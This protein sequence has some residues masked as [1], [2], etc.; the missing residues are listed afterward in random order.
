[1]LTA[2]AG[3]GDV[4]KALDLG[5]N[6]YLIKP[7]DIEELIARVRNL[8][9]LGKTEDVLRDSISVL[10]H[11][12]TLGNIT[13]GVAHDLNN[14][15]SILEVHELIDMYI[16]KIK[17]EQTKNQI[18]ILG[19]YFD[20]IEDS[21]SSIKNSLEYGTEMCKSITDFVRGSG[22]LKKYQQIGPLIN[23][24]INILKRILK[25]KRITIIKDFEKDITFFCRAN[26]VKRMIMNL[27][28]NSVHALNNLNNSA[29]NKKIIY[30]KLRKKSDF[31]KLSISDNGAGISPDILHRIF[32]PLFTTKGESGNGIGLSTIKKIVD[33]YNGSIQVE[34]ELNKGTCFILLF[35][36]D[37]KNRR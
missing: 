2:K 14:I 22:F 24:P 32:D 8:V 19:M 4:V 31:L 18:K 13:A 30:M 6:D 10:E 7:F 16:K 3:T 34:S 23:N 15:L 26:D 12:A 25:S 36:I 17:S 37:Q 27:L 1:M 35:P 28:T 21:C 5:A 33:S 20:K 11:E 29:V 9:K